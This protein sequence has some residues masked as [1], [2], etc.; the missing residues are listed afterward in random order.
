MRVAFVQQT[1]SILSPRLLPLLCCIA[2]LTGTLAAQDTPLRIEQTVEPE[3]PRSLIFTNVTRGRAGVVIDVDYRGTLTDILVTSYTRK[4]FAD[5]ALAVL[6]R[7]RF[8]PA[9]AQGRPIGVRME[10]L[11]DFTAAGKVFTLLPIETPDILY[12]QTTT[13]QRMTRVVC[14]P[15]ELDRPITPIAPVSPA[16]PGKPAGSA[17]QSVVLDFYVDETGLP[18]MPVVLASP[19]D[20]LSQAA[21]GALTQWRFNPPTRGGKPVSVRV[22]QEFIFPGT[23]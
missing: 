17:A 14:R 1:P 7:W 22:Q 21:M 10:L 13:A 11:F 18:R 15:Q 6:R 19:H 12:A 9:T 4:E 20:V 2:A 5:E 3:F 16:N 23:S 8:T